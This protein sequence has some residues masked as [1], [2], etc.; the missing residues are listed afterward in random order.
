LLT[1]PSDCWSSTF[2]LISRGDFDFEREPVT[3]G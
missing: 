3:K 2:E 1:P